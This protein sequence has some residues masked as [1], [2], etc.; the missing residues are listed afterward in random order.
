MSN[1]DLI[2]QK[3]AEVE[4]LL[5]ELADLGA[6]NIINARVGLIAT[7]NTLSRYLPPPKN[8]QTI[9]NGI[10]LRVQNYRP[11]PATEIVPV[12]SDAFYAKPEP[13]P[14]PPVS[15][16]PSLAEPPPAPKNVTENEQKKN[17]ATA[18]ATIN[19]R[20]TQTEIAT[21]LDNKTPQ[22]QFAER[23][24]AAEILQFQKELTSQNVPLP[25]MERTTQK[26]KIL[27]IKKCLE[28]QK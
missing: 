14:A 16:Q 5:G 21:I 24:T 17:V 1:N 11:K 22:P 13:K 23:F 19:A 8:P 9:A 4:T 10:F 27:V 3:L 15:E 7:F 28:I 26:F 18:N 12:F 25:R 6:F 2:K 20:L